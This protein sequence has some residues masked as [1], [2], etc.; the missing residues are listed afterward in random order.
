MK[1]VLDS[2]LLIAFFRKEKN[3]RKVKDFFIKAKKGKYKIF[4]CWINLIEVYYKIYRKRGKIAADKAL[5]LIK[6][7]PLKLVLPDESLFLN[8]ARIKGKYTIALADCFIVALAYELEA[9]VLTGD[10]EFQKVTKIVRVLW[11]KK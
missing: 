6:K 4:L 5:S 2:C 8:T 9:V 1:L 11:L 3:W 7:L 10:P